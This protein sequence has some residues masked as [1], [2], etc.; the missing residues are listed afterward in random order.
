[1]NTMARL[2]DLDRLLSRTAYHPPPPFHEP[3]ADDRSLGPALPKPPGDVI[4][5]E[6]LDGVS[7]RVAV[8]PDGSHLIGTRGRWLYAGGDVIADAAHGLVAAVRPAAER[9]SGEPGG[10]LAVWGELIGGGTA[11]AGR[12]TGR[13]EVG[14]G[15]FD[16]LRVN[17]GDEGEPEYLPE[18]EL[19]AFAERSALPLVP[20]VARFPARDLPTKPEAVRTL[21]EELLPNSRCRLDADAADAPAGL[22]VRTPDRGWIATMRADKYR[23]VRKRKR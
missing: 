1:M 16:V 7:F 20:R 10:V 6:L 2:A 15:V 22:V 8:F 23:R 4:A 19:L 21:L 17:L 9:I 11:G 12:Y 14:F 3:D 13:R 5:T 18:K